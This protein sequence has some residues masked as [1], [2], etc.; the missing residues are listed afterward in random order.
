MTNSCTA[1]SSANSASCCVPRTLFLIASPGLYSIIG[2]CLCAAAW[3]TMLGRCSRKICSSRW[4]SVMSQMQGMIVVS[5]LSKRNS[6]S[7]R[8]RLFSSSLSQQQRAKGAELEHLPADFRADA[9]TASRDHDG[10]AGDQGAD[11]V[12]IEFHRSTAEKVV[13]VDVAQLQAVVA[14][15]QFFESRDHLQSEAG[16]FAIVDQPAK[17]ATHEQAGDDQNVIHVGQASSSP[18]CRWAGPG[19]GCHPTSNRGGWHL[20]RQNR[21]HVAPERLSAFRWRTS[22]SPR[23]V[24]TNRVMAL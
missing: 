10:A 14:R 15:H 16:L 12:A 22:V 24:S 3:N 2:T 6:C 4:R 9:S 17:L 23:L 21:R 7:T 8:N 19:P 18:R 1:Y 13:D 5:D 20:D 11:G